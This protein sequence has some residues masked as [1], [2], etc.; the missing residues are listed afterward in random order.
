MCICMHL[1]YV[2]M[3]TYVW[4]YLKLKTAHAANANKFPPVMLEHYMN[5]TSANGM[6]LLE[7]RYVHMYVCNV[8]W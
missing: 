6:N 2:C 3:H 1:I 8:Q 4:M 5:I 7:H